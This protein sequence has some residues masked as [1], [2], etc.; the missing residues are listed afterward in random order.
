[1]IGAWLH[2]HTRVHTGAD[3]NPDQDDFGD[4]AAAD[5]AQGQSLQQRATHT[6]AYTVISPN[7][8]KRRQITEQAE[9][10]TREYEQY[11]QQN[12]PTRVSYVGTV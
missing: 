8:K 2:L 1:M 3:L 10:G 5:N 4:G 12:K 11:K 9:R 7:E 6:G